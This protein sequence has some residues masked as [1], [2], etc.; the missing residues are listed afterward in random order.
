MA[1]ESFSA[2]Y[3]EARARFR[4]ACDA[5]GAVLVS[6]VHPRER[7]PDGGILSVETAVL[8]DADAALMIVSGTH[9][10]EGFAG[11]GIQTA[12]LE[13]GL[14][15]RLARDLRVVMVHAINPYGFA[16]CRRFNEDNVDLNRNFVAFDRPLPS[17]PD[18]LEARRRIFGAQ[19]APAD[20]NAL[21]TRLRAEQER[22]GYAGLLDCFQPGQ[23][24]DSAGLF[25]GGKA[26]SWSNGLFRRICRETLRGARRV[27]GVDLHTG[28]GPSG[29]GEILFL[30]AG[31]RSSR[32]AHGAVFSPPVSAAGD[33][34]SV[35]AP[36]VGPLIG[37]LAEEI[38][39]AD[40]V[41]GV[42]EFGTLPLPEV[43]NALFDEHW[44]HI[45]LPQGHPELHAARARLRAAFHREGDLAWTKAL[46]GRMEAIC[47]DAARYLLR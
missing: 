5:A 37:A 41:A 4:A 21:K 35:S 44:A 32:I 29:V 8:G 27:V 24:D 43:L 12:L 23:Y 2:T 14:A 30:G 18:A 20:R 47:L 9:G 17:N 28:L 13:T 11:S 10:V 46:L 26:P 36:V 1:I 31:S 22:D 3:A 25:F 7:A 45:N 40:I 19:G 39:A 6:H 15:A 33:L 42:L 34:D 16:Y 38:D